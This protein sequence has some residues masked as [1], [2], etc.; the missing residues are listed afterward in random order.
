METQIAIP[1][2][3]EIYNMMFAGISL[4]AI[5][6][7]PIKFTSEKEVYEFWALANR[8]SQNPFILERK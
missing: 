4:E 8:T 1:T 5:L 6:D 3:K 7:M 2:H